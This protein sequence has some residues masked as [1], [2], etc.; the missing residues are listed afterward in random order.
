[1]PTNAQIPISNIY[2]NTAEEDNEIINSSPYSI[3]DSTDMLDATPNNLIN[4]LN[5][6]EEDNSDTALLTS[7]NITPR[8]LE[9]NYNTNADIMSDNNNIEEDLGN[10]YPGEDT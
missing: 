7:S 9:P 3:T 8:K 10:L 5:Q 1:M 6:S 2:N 4:R